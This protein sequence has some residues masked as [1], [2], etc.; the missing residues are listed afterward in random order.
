IRA[1]PLRQAGFSGAMLPVMEDSV[2]G[3]RVAE[4]RVSISELLL[5]STVCGTGLDTVPLPG[6]TSVSEIAALLT[7]VAGLS[8]QLNKPLT[9]RLFPV[10][11]KAAG[12]LT[13]F[14]FPFFSNTRVMGLKGL[15]NELFLR[16]AALG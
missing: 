1:A 5:Y 13:E 14:N 7:D 15:T 11:G 12:E 3:R 9:A 8:V 16:R 10:P 4:G 6:S 2:L